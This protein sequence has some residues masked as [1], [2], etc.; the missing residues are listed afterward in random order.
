MGLI[1]LFCGEEV[2]LNAAVNCWPAFAV[3]FFL[4]VLLPGMAWAWIIPETVCEDGA[5][6]V[7]RLFDAA[8]VI[9]A[10]VLVAVLA[11]L[12][13]AELG[14]YTPWLEWTATALLALIGFLAGQARGLDTGDVFR[15]YAPVAAA[16]AVVATIPMLLPARG[17]WIVGGWDPGIY[18]NTGVSVSGSGGFRPGPDPMFSLFTAEELQLFTRLRYNFTE[19]YPV[20][21]VDP[22]TRYLEPL[23][24][25]LT[26]SLIALMDR[27]GGLRAAVR[28][29]EIVAVL[30]LV[31]FFA[32]MIVLSPRR[33]QAFLALLFLVLQ[34]IFLYQAHLPTSEMLQ[35]LL[36][37][38]LGMVLP[39][40]R[41][42]MGQ[43]ALLL[44]L[45]AAEVNRFSFLLFGG[46]LLFSTAWLD[47][48]RED[49]RRVREERALQVG[50]LGLG[51]AYAFVF[52]GTTMGRIYLAIPPLLYAFAFLV[53]AAVCLDLL[54][55]QPAARA[56]L[57]RWVGRLALGG[58]L[59][60]LAGL[61][62]MGFVVHVPR[63]RQFR[64]NVR[65]LAW[66]IGP[67]V[68]LAAAAGAALL[69]A[70]RKPE[71]LRQKAW[72][73]FLVVATAVSLENSG[74][75]PL[76][77][78]SVRRYL[79]FT[80]PLVA[81][82]SAGAFAGLAEG[83]EAHARRWKPVAAVLAAVV[84]LSILPRSRQAWSCT[85]FNGA[86]AALARIARAIG[87]D[88]IVVADHFRWGTPLR[89]IY[90]KRVIN[91]ELFYEDPSPER[92]RRAL[93]ALGRLRDRGW[94][95]RF[96]TSTDRELTVFPVGVEGAAWDGVKEPFLLVDVA[97]RRGRAG[98]DMSDRWKEFRLF[99]W[100]SE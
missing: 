76:W 69:A 33:S 7:R 85:E 23:F 66:Y 64:S 82:L 1:G 52:S 15:R 84:L 25:H 93:T 41:S 72:A 27:C 86:S 88:D 50:A 42:A 61:L 28:V 51:A 68:C 44:L 73:L 58:G 6:W 55:T 94:R 80:M 39:A 90:G 96:L 26:P 22:S 45:F 67:L 91:G 19:A 12:A 21:P 18:V 70:R 53:G 4:R 99:T 95:V 65:Q 77:P 30:A 81:L 54:A 9:L 87:P 97:H 40:R 62:L 63:M 16:L 74:I 2:G 11:T 5:P 8:R 13:L 83:C 59:G 57:A 38:G 24:F 56:W 49:R 79:Q 32:M 37:C 17:E 35:L 47:L 46:L 98:F 78:W 34:P 60:L 71:Y 29:N 10:G 14:V 43:A 100:Q 36:L 89:F 31:V 3:L 20:V 75:V 48:E 92:M